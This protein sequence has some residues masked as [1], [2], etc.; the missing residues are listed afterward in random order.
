MHPNTYRRRSVAPRPRGRPSRIKRPGQLSNTLARPSAVP[1]TTGRGPFSPAPGP[2]HIQ[3]PSPVCRTLAPSDHPLP[4]SPGFDACNSQNSCQLQP[5]R[6][7]PGRLRGTA[8]RLSNSARSMS[9]SDPMPR[10][11]T[12][13]KAGV[14]VPYMFG[15]DGAGSSPSSELPPLPWRAGPGRG[16]RRL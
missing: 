1:P 15:A 12:R 10:E 13:R 9:W 3:R 14:G 16:H 2:E 4:G 6:C 8:S 7:S 11:V 5:S